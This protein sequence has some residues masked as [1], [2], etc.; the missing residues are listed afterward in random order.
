MRT[1]EYDEMQRAARENDIRL[2]ARTLIFTGVA[3]AIIWQ[4]V[5]GYA[6]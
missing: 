1:G 3:C 2:I 4:L 5:R 6:H